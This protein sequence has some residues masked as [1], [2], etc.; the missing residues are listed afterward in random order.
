MIRSGLESFGLRIWPVAL[1]ALGATLFAPTLFGG[2]CTVG[3]L[4]SYQTGV[5]SGCTIDG[6]TV[7]FDDGDLSDSQGFSATGVNQ[8]TPSD[9]TVTPTFT[10][11]SFTIEFS[12]PSDFLFEGQAGGN[13]YEFDYT[14]DPVLPKIESVTENTGPGDPPSLSGLFCGDGIILN[15]VCED[16]TPVS[17]SMV[18]SGSS[19]TSATATFPSPQTDLETELTLV[20]DPCQTI[21]NFGSTVNLVPEPSMLWLTPGLVGLIFLRKKWLAKGR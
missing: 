13:T 21:N 11:T 5:N 14:L 15:G 1:C 12:T 9:I 4:A 17:I 2:T 7:D 19:Q 18:A 6:Y 3:T 10:A 20:L 16:G 8:L